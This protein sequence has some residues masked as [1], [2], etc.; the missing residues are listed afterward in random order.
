[1]IMKTKTNDLDCWHDEFL[2]YCQLDEE[3]KGFN[4]TE[5]C[6]RCERYDN[7]NKLYP[8]K[9][10]DIDGKLCESCF[11]KINQTKEV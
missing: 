11:E 6:L 1:M 2:K 8:T 9:W 3:L 7:P 4:L 5:L 10:L